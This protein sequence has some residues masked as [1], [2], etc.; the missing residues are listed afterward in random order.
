MYNIFSTDLPEPRRQG[1]RGDYLDGRVVGLVGGRNA[2]C[3]PRGG[4]SGGGV[5]ARKK[6]Y[7]DAILRKSFCPSLPNKLI[8]LVVVVVACKLLD[9]TGGQYRYH[10]EG[11][12][13]KV[14]GK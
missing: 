2:A 14:R 11:T 3:V 10:S 5:P 8:G 4:D 13:G 12:C 6:Q 1:D 9:G 7:F